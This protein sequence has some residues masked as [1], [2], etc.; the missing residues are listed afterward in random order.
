MRA[1]QCAG[2]Q[3]SLPWILCLATSLYVRLCAL[4]CALLCVRLCVCRIQR[5]TTRTTTQGCASSCSRLPASCMPDTSPCQRIFQNA[6]VVYLNT[7]CS[8]QS[9]LRFPED[10]KGKEMLANCRGAW[11]AVRGI[12]RPLAVPG[13][14]VLAG[15]RAVWCTVGGVTLRHR[16]A[17]VSMVRGG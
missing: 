12:A 9:E 14:S 1:R 8:V 2:M 6:A 13:S 4:L 7:V 17:V 5:A 15:E 10:K 11:R 3:A 16:P